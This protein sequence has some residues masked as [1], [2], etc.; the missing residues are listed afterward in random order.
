M[1]NKY[2]PQ[3]IILLFL[4][5]HVSISFA[6]PSLLATLEGEGTG[7]FFGC[8]VSFGNF[9]NDSWGDILIG[10][11]EAN[12]GSGEAY[13]YYGSSS[14]NNIVDVTLG[15]GGSD[16]SLGTAVAGHSSYN[17]DGY[18]DAAIGLP[19]YSTNTGRIYI[20]YGGNPMNNVVDVTLTGTSSG[21]LFGAAINNYAADFNCDSYS[22]IAVGAPGYSVNT[23]RVYIFWGGNPMNTTA[24][25]IITGN[26]G[27]DKFG[28]SITCAKVTD[29]DTLD[30]IIGA[31]GYSNSTGRVYIYKG[32]R[33]A[34]WTLYR[35]YTGESV[36]DQF[37]YSVHARF[38]NLIIGAP[39]RNNYEGKIYVYRNFGNN[40]NFT[41]TGEAIG[42]EFGSSVCNAN[43]TNLFSRDSN[44]VIVGAP[45]YSTSV[46]KT[47]SY[48]TSRG[49]SI[50]TLTN[51]NTGEKFGYSISSGKAV[52]GQL[53]TAA[54]DF[55]IGAPGW[56]TYQG[57]VYVYTNDTGNG[58]NDG[59]L[60]NYNATSVYSR[61]TVLP[62]PFQ[63]EITFLCK[64]PSNT[65]Y[66]LY[67]F[68]VAG[69]KVRTIKGFSTGRNHSITWD[70]RDDTGNFL[71]DGI[72]FYRLESPVLHASGKIVAE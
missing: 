17:G 58:N 51:N 67:F 23:G 7:D 40:P 72:Y 25:V 18:T 24:D 41:K 8:A 12:N 53:P 55:A 69:R 10:A 2:I 39:G 47:Y 64:F 31:P 1:L 59:I 3:R 42:D 44:E 61:F 38:G 5:L 56:S 21:E 43:T 27:G 32:S 66:R 60:R 63:D 15:G 19:G 22:D 52:D 26:S 45:E 46:G 50:W 70:R 54:D 35:T 48:K 13:I 29:D 68:D 37:G 34:T 16:D 36:G 65:E 30:I 62:N 57:H 14:F 49:T 20:Y 9:N 28:Y 71:R 33:A 4:I 6:T 11:C